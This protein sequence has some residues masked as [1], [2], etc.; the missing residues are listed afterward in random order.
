VTP[1]TP[2]VALHAPEERW[3]IAAQTLL[4]QQTVPMLTRAIDDLACLVH[5]PMLP[6]QLR[7]NARLTAIRI[8][9]S[10][11]L[12]E[13]FVEKLGDSEGDV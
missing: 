4:T 5:D 8:A 7:A 13:C 6:E 9:E 11:V 10:A 1:P 2:D 12:L 3:R